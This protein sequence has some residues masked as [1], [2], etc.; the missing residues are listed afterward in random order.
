MGGRTP[1]ARA[2]TRPRTQGPVLDDQRPR[3]RP[4]VRPVVARAGAGGRGPRRL[5]AAAG[6]AA[7]GDRIGLPGEPPF[8]RGIHPTGY[9]SRLWTMRMFAGF[10]AAEDTNARFH[11]SSRRARPVCPS[12]MTCRPCTATT[13]TILRPRASS[14]R[15]AWRSAASRTWRSCSTA[16]RSSA[17]RRDD[18]QLAGRA[19]LGDV[20][21][22]RGEAGVPRGRPSR[23]RPRTTSSRSSSPRRSSCSRPTRQCAS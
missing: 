18:D 10:G 14:G 2:R 8:T 13:P 12:P 21:R 15:A 17:S 11:Q 9:R 7:A 6:S 23:A 5:A 20:H 3:D 19:D 4:A 1:R 22:G 16:C